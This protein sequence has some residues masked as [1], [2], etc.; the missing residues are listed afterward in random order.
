MAVLRLW[1][2]KCS[3][4]VKSRATHLEHHCLGPGLPPD[5]ACLEALNHEL[6]E[7]TSP[8]RMRGAVCAACRALSNPRGVAAVH[9][10][11]TPQPETYLPHVELH[12]KFFSVKYPDL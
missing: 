7:A 1:R 12:V 4:A 6:V 11:H 3:R 2:A 5:T 9:P 10:L 8:M